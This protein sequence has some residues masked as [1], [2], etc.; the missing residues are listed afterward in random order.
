MSSLLD[1]ELAKRGIDLN[2]VN[3]FSFAN[4][5]SR[6]KTFDSL[7][8]SIL[9]DEASG[10]DKAKLYIK[11]AESYKTAEKVLQ[12]L[13]DFYYIAVDAQRKA[14]GKHSYHLQVLKAFDKEDNPL[15][16]AL[17]RHYEYDRGTASDR[18]DPFWDPW[19]DITSIGRE[20]L[21][22]LRQH[23]NSIKLYKPEESP[24][25]SDRGKKEPPTNYRNFYEWI[26]EVLVEAFKVCL[27]YEKVKHHYDCLAGVQRAQNEVQC[28]VELNLDRQANFKCELRFDNLVAWKT[29][30]KLCHPHIFNTDAP[31]DD[32]IQ[33]SNPRHSATALVPEDSLNP[34]NSSIAAGTSELNEDES[35]S[36]DAISPAITE[37]QQQ[38]GASSFPRQ[39]MSGYQQLLLVAIKTVWQVLA[40][41][42]T[43]GSR[44]QLHNLSI[45]ADRIATKSRIASLA[46]THSTQIRELERKLEEALQSK[47]NDFQ[48]KK[49]LRKQ[50][51]QAQEK[52]VQASHQRA[53]AVAKAKEAQEILKQI[54]EL[55]E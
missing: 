1:V 53:E 55:G 20:N 36:N 6:L 35:T 11:F 19:T 30:A 43:Q 7:V 34:L 48:E 18:L 16:E 4:I 8:S 40:D 49:E 51:A 24:R 12:T 47:E 27:D 28:K 33:S 46:H 26:F 39:L 45:L 29:H 31:A 25:R 15:H 14:D 10:S 37:A 38:D 42:T 41:R 2:E 21:N 52:I 54:V 32:S 23:W 13:L 17:G 5:V 3:S 9:L 22:S 50:L 44:R